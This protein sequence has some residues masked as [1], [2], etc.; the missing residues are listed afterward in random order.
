[1]EHLGHVCPFVLVHLQLEFEEFWV[2]FEVQMERFSQ[3]H[4]LVPAFIALSKQ[5][6]PA[7]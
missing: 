5:K 3:D 1:M 6:E 7:S 2:C 4:R